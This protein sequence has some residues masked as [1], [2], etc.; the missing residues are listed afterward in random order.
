MSENLI[1]ENLRQSL[2]TAGSALILPEEPQE[3]DYAAHIKALLKAEELASVVV[4]MAIGNAF[5]AMHAAWGTKFDTAKTHFGEEQAKKIMHY[6]RIARVWAF[7]QSVGWSWTYYVDLVAYSQTQKEY[8]IEQFQNGKLRALS[9]ISGRSYSRPPQQKT[10]FPV[11]GKL[12]NHQLFADRVDVSN[13]VTYLQ[14]TTPEPASSLDMVADFFGDTPEPAEPVLRV[15]QPPVSDD[16]YLM[17]S[18]PALPA[19]APSQAARTAVCGGR[20]YLQADPCRHSL[21]LFEGDDMETPRLEIEKQDLPGIVRLAF[22]AATPKQREQY[23]KMLSE[24][25]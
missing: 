10:Q 17:P 11:N 16:P 1:A 3:E 23:A 14:Q 12:E 21:L 20:A 7:N 13:P 15:N 4:R 8:Q 18:R 25:A 9:Q 2:T 24:A 5:N 19:P 22:L 6:G